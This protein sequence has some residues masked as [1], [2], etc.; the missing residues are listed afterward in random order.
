MPQLAEIKFWVRKRLLNYRFADFSTQQYMKI[1]DD[2]ADRVG[3][4]IHDENEIRRLAVRSAAHYNGQ[5]VLRP[6]TSRIVTELMSWFLLPLALMRWSMAGMLHKGK[7]APKVAGVRWNQSEFV[8]RLN[9]SMFHT[10]PELADDAPQTVFTQA[11]YLRWRDIILLMR[12]AYYVRPYVGIFAQQWLFKVAK[13][14][15]W[16]RPTLDAYPSEYALFD[17]ETDCAFSMLTL[18]ARQNGQKL[19]NVMHGDKYRAS[20]D[21]FFEADRC[22]CWSEFYVEQFKLL[23]VRS[24]FRIYPNPVFQLSEEEKT[25]R[26]EGLGVFMPISETMPRE[27]DRQAFASAMNALAEHFPV[28]IRP[29]P[30]HVNHAESFRSLL[31]GKV[32]IVAPRGESSCQFILRHKVILGSVTTA[33]LESVM[34]GRPTVIFSSSYGEDAMTYHYMYREPN[35]HVCP[36]SELAKTAERYLTA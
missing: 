4:A 12:A 13:E 36:L 21:A 33:L 11:R 10:P 15:A 18:F 16:A 17:G 29:H 7:S 28:H 27:E 20:S 9:P 5:L 2:I 22:Y 1:V 24:E 6:M 34:L 3:D 23:H 31:S 30:T 19:Y 26:G 8:Y 25:R 32:E 14:M 35:C